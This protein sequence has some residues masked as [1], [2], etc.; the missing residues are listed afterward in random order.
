MIGAVDTHA[1]TAT[2]E[3]VESEPSDWS[4]EY[5]IVYNSNCF[6]GSLT[7]G[8]NGNAGQSV[9][10]S[11]KKITLDDKYAM[12]VAHPDG[13]TLQT[14][15]GYYIGRGANSNGVDASNTTSYTVSFGSWNS[16]N[17]TI[18]ISGTGGR[19]L[20][21]NSGSWKFFASSNAYVNVSLYKKASSC[22]NKVTI[23]KD[24]EINGT[25]NPSQL[26]CI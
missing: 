1:A 4:G 20:G 14:A 11:N 23:Q 13:Y 25:Y 21:N 26:M 10:I 17:K 16:T 12:I 3:L 6:N 24:D 19:C 15:S 2:W 9:T 8:F 22:K 5:L 18:K 7:S